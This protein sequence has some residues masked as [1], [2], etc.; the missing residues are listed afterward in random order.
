MKNIWLRA[1]HTPMYSHQVRILRQTA[2]FMIGVI[3]SFNCMFQLSTINLTVIHNF[4]EGRIRRSICWCYDIWYGG[5]Y[6]IFHEHVTFEYHASQS[7]MQISRDAYMISKLNGHLTQFYVIATCTLHT[8]KC[9]ITHEIP[10]I[11]GLWKY[12]FSIEKLVKHTDISAL[13]SR[14][15]SCS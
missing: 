9:V 10:S 14:M 5:L 7:H 3:C 4:P 12:M 1:N 8:F 6:L 11:I 2:L 15:I 13:I